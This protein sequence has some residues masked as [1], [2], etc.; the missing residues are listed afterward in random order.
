MNP[1]YFMDFV[2]WIKVTLWHFT[3]K[4]C[5]IDEKRIL[6]TVFIAVICVYP[7]IHEDFSVV[8]TGTGQTIILIS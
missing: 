6:Y 1:Q 4:Q 8:D 2:K 5:R 3:P 7:D